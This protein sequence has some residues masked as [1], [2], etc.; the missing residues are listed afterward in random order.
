[1]INRVSTC[2]ILI[3]IN[4]RENEKTQGTFSSRRDMYKQRTT[5]TEIVTVMIHRA[6]WGKKCIVSFVILNDKV[7]YT[8]GLNPKEVIKYWIHMYKFC[9]GELGIIPYMELTLRRGNVKH[10][11]AQF[12]CENVENRAGYDNTYNA[13]TKSSYESYFSENIMYLYSH[14]IY[15]QMNYVV[16]L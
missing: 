8:Y 16:K 7:N 4:G 1:M 2:N 9:P 13:W 5:S 10:T 3:C 15:K 12:C 14:C 6:K 11:L